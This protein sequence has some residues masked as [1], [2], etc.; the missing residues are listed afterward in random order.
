MQ[1][2]RNFIDR[3][4][5]L[6]LVG[7]CLTTSLAPADPPKP[8]AAPKPS[9]AVPTPPPVASP[10]VAQQ[11]STAVPTPPPPAVAEP[12]PGDAGSDAVYRY[13][14]NRMMSEAPQSLELVIEAASN[15]HPDVAAAN[16]EI[17]MAEAKL[18]KARMEAVRSAV[19]AW[20]KTRSLEARMAVVAEDLSKSPGPNPDLVAT[21]TELKATIE[22]MKTELAGMTKKAGSNA[23]WVTRLQMSNDLPTAEVRYRELSAGGPG[24]GSQDYFQLAPGGGFAL[25]V[26]QA[27]KLPQ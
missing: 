7:L 21:L 2:M 1:A 18:Q 6:A 25:A 27:P 10:P 16:A 14:L 9:T 22:Q 19:A 20:N 8:T 17:R 23:A 15:N 4:A 24:S 13:S 26:P 12:T 3:P 11:P 5:R